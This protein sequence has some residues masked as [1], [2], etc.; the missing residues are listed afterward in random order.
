MSDLPAIMGGAAI[1]GRSA[2]P[3]W[4]QWGDTER[5]ALIATL[6]E[7]GWWTGDGGRAQGFADDFAHYHG[8]THGLP[9]TNGTH[10]I[11]AALAACDIGEGDEVIVPGLSFVATATAVL[12]VNAVPVLVDIEPGSL[13]IDVAAAVAAISARTRAIIAVHVAGAAC[14]LDALTELCTRRGLHL[15]ED[16]AHAHGSFWRGRGV[17]SYGT[18]GSFSMQRSK[19]LT[20]GEGGALIG[21][22]LAL[23]ERAWTY[24]NCG[25]VRG[26]HWYHHSGYGSNLRMTEFQGALLAAQ[27]E[28]FADQ[29]QRRNASA[30]ALNAAL[31][32]IPGLEPQTRDPRM[33][34]QGNYCY[35]FHY[36][37]REFSGLSLAGF[38]AALEAEGVPLAGSYPALN[39]LQMFRT[40]NFAPRFRTPPRDYSTV[41]LP[42]AEHAASSTVWMEHRVLLADPEAVLDVARACERIR[43]HAGAISAKTPG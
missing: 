30:L 27:F 13:N 19:L 18:F 2:W 8:A 36:D 43:E 15:I 38:E 17:G 20:A 11:E 7:G 25:R 1:C 24:S 37:P 39:T 5:S 42:R 23:M 35:V 16:C 32:S 41:V 31:T 9:F 3:Q 21:S 10:T 14:D 29:N 34:S 22:D 6:D 33:D 12:A 40:N 26:R 4:P 28:R